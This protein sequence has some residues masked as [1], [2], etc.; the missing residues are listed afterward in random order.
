MQGTVPYYQSGHQHLICAWCDIW[1]RILPNYEMTRMY[2]DYGEAFDHIHDFFRGVPMSAY[3]VAQTIRGVVK[4]IDGANE[5][6]YRSPRL[7]ALTTELLLLAE[8]VR[9]GDFQRSY[10]RLP[11]GGPYYRNDRLLLGR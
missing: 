3:S 5:L 7:K 8:L 4:Y 11:G 6:H 2:R 9:C 10:S 1:Q